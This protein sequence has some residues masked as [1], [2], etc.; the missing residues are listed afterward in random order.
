M[1]SI[2]LSKSSVG[3]EEKDAVLKVLDKENLQV[4]LGFGRNILR[5]N[6]DSF[7]EIPK[8]NHIEPSLFN[9]IIQAISPSKFKAE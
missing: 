3:Q 8:T 7:V 5:K 4:D 6:S 9:N 2:R 1:D